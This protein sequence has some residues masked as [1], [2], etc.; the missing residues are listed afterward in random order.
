MNVIYVPI[1]GTVDHLVAGLLEEPAGPA[2]A[3][4]ERPCCSPSPIHFSLPQVQME[5]EEEEDG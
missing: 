5:D 3:E 2:P 4:E 1:R